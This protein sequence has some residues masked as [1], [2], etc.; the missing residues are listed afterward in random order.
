MKNRAIRIAR[1]LLLPITPRRHR[2]ALDYWTHRLQGICEPELEHLCLFAKGDGIAIDAGA[3]VGLYSYR[4]ARIFH[5]VYAFEINDAVVKNLIAWEN[6]RIRVTTVGLSSEVGEATLYVPIV[7]GM[8][9]NAWGSLNR[10]NCPDADRLIE[11]K[12]QLAP[13]DSFGLDGVAF[14]KVDVEGHESELLQGAARTI[15]QS[16]PVILIEVRAANLSSVR[17]F[18]EKRGYTMTNLRDLVGIQGQEGNFIFLP[19][20]GPKW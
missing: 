15:E 13:L 18:L 16:R 7:K 17:S 2:L 9:L 8:V 12:V 5:T 11:K 20:K 6:P 3:N 10:T 1:R 4:L 14:L 19:G